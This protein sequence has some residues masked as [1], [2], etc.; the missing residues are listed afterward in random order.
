MAINV[1]C[2][3]DHLDTAEALKL[4]LQHEGYDVTVTDSANNAIQLIEQTQYNAFILD[5]HLP[6]KSGLELCRWIRAASKDVPIIIYSGASHKSELDAACLAGATRY[7]IKP[8]DFEDIISTVHE[9]TNNK[10]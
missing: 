10:R 7:L 3:D 9:L 6:D 1:L 8:A 5:T 4:L 2:V